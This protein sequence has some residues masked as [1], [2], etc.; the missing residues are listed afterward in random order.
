MLNPL[1]P[2]PPAFPCHRPADLVFLIDGSYSI[3]PPDW[4]KGKR[5]VSYLINSL[6]I[7]PDSIHV[8]IVVYGSDIGDVVP[9]QP[10]KGE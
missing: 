9:L 3:S 6:D 7:G 8:G 4:I 2:F 10:F 1:T 5:F